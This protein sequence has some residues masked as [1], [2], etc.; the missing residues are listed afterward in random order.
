MDTRRHFLIGFCALLLLAAAG[1]ALLSAPPVNAQAGCTDKIVDGGFETG[2]AWQLGISPL[3]PE[4]VTYAQHSGEKSLALGITRGGGKP[5]Y[6]SARQTV[7]IPPGATKVTLSFWF[8]AMV[9]GVARP[10]A[11]QLI[12]LNPDGS[13]LATPWKSSNDSRVWNQMTTDLTRWRGRTVQIYFNV[14][15]DGTSNTAGMFLDDVSLVVCGPTP[16]P[17]PSRTPTPTAGLTPVYPTQPPTRTVTPTR[18]VTP[19]ATPT[20]TNCAE[21]L[22]NGGFEN[23]LAPWEIGSSALP[24]LPVPTPVRNGVWALRLGTQTGNIASQSPVRQIVAIPPASQTATLR[25][26]LWTWVDYPDGV[27]RQEAQLFA[28]DGSLLRTLWFEL[29]NNPTWR[30]FEADLSPYIGQ[31][32][33]LIFNVYNDGVNGRAAMFLDD[34]SLVICG[35]QPSLA[36][37]ARAMTGPALSW[38]DLGRGPAAGPP[39]AR[40]LGAAPGGGSTSPAEPHMTRLAIALTPAPSAT[41]GAARAPEVTTAPAETARPTAATRSQVIET[42]QK[43]WWVIVIALVLLAALAILTSRVGRP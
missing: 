28:A 2:D 17:T 19:T 37:A 12:L 7:T 3:T 23:G 43:R 42:W 39:L 14:Y 5:G 22:Q 36:P 34:A 25:F 6:S 8:N 35:P 15:N 4:Y 27:D 13:T 32:V 38:P 9:E 40:S 26:Y 33:Q 20:P 10:N 21:V 24:A 41:V 16:S 18:S 11:M 31:T 30:A 1:W 29:S